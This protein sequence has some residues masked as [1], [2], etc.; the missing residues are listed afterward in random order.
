MRQERIYYVS[1]IQDTIF[2]VARTTV[3]N[4]VRWRFLNQVGKI[5]NLLLKV[6]HEEAQLRKQMHESFFH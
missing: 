6:T 5:R 1:L 2:C 3:A 4:G